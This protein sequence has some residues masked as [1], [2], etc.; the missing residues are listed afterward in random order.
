MSLAS[1][2]LRFLPLLLLAALTGCSALED[3]MVNLNPFR[4]PSGK[5]KIVIDLS[6]QKAWLYRGREVAAVSRISS[7]REGY[8]TPTGNFSVIQKDADHRSS[9]YGAYVLKGTRK[10]VVADVDTRKTKPPAGTTYI[11]APMPY[12]LRFQ[13]GHGLHAGNV[14]NY[15]ASHGC[16]RLPGFMAK[17]FYDGVRLGTPVI[18]RR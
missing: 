1:K 11:G 2:F 16:I 14:P 9:V 3:P 10:I 7:G 13:G 15:P 17:K 4:N 8:D 12:F 5:A 6:Q 18:V